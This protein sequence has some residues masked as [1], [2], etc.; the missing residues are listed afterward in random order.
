[1]QLSLNS[2]RV[3]V[4]DRALPTRWLWR[5]QGTLTLHV[6]GKNTKQVCDEVDH[7]WKMQNTKSNW[8]RSSFSIIIHGNFPDKW[9]KTFNL[10]RPSLPS[11]FSTPGGLS[12]PRC[13][14]TRA[15]T[16]FGIAVFIKGA[17]KCT[18]FQAKQAC[19]RTEADSNS[20]PSPAQVNILSTSNVSQISLSCCQFVLLSLYSRRGWSRSCVSLYSLDSG[21]SGCWKSFLQLLTDWNMCRNLALNT[22]KDSDPFSP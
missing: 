9:C 12:V 1:M 8:R 6:W 7:K 15:Y 11:G 19:V 10:S 3:R 5:E 17:L 14:L 18:F 20:S 16:F 22:C 21:T 2:G 13:V 4:E